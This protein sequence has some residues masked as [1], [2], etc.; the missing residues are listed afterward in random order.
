[1]ASTMTVSQE[2]TPVS[3]PVPISQ[4]TI[5]VTAPVSVPVA[6]SQETNTTAPVSIPV[7]VSQDTINVTTAPVSVPVT[8]P[9]SIPM[10]DQGHESSAVSVPDPIQNTESRC[11]QSQTESDQM[12]AKAPKTNEKKPIG[13][14]VSSN[15]KRVYP[16]TT[17]MDSPPS[18]SEIRGG[19]DSRYEKALERRAEKRRT[20][21]QHAQDGYKAFLDQL[22]SANDNLSAYL[23]S[24]VVTIVTRMVNDGKSEFYWQFEKS[25]PD[26]MD[27]RGLGVNTVLFGRYD[28]MRVDKGKEKGEYVF[29]H[30]RLSRVE[31]G[32]SYDFWTGMNSRLMGKGYS[33][34]D[35][36]DR[37]KG[38]KKFVLISIH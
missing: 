21:N 10:M 18:I 13:K 33:V 28:R 34:R 30:D 25:I 3:V 22:K 29:P 32:L 11:Y 17:E 19:S 35:V 37:S 12:S 23:M 6:I 31:A 9:I 36:T 20:W 38:P 15:S 27:L 24:E 7:T 8:V 2:T 16:V 26:D 5:N 14:K 1:M 4:E